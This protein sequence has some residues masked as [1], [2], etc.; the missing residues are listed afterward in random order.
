MKVFSDSIFRINI[1]GMK[2][3]RIMFITEINCYF[4]DEYMVMTR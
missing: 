1:K 4:F 3:K 2:S